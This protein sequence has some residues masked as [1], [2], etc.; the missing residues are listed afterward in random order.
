[1]AITNAQQYQQLVN[2]PAGNK[3]PGYR[4]D[5]AYGK[6][7]G[8][9]Q[10]RS[11]G[12]A[13]GQ[14]GPGRKNES[15]GDGPAPRADKS[16][17]YVQYDPKIASDRAT[18]VA[19]E[20]P[21][22]F[23]NRIPT[24][25]GIARK[26]INRLMKN[27][28]EKNRIDYLK[29]NFPE[30]FDS[31]EDLEK[32]GKEDLVNLPAYLQGL[33]DDD[34]LYTDQGLKM[35]QNLGKAE[36]VESFE[37]FMYNVKGS[38]GLKLAGN[39]GQLGTR[40]AVRDADGNIIGYKFDEKR[41]GGRDDFILPVSQPVA[42]IP[43]PTGYVNPLSLLTPRIAGTRFLG[44]EFKDEEDTEFAADGGRIGA[45]DGG[46][47]NVEDL[48]REA[49]IFG[50]IAKGLKK[51]VRGVKK[52]VKSPIGKAALIGAGFGF[53]GMGP[54]KGLAGSKFGLGLK[55]FMAFGNPDKAFDIT[56]KGFKLGQFIADNPYKTIGGISLLA[57][58]LAGKQED[59][60]DELAKY[61]ASQKLDPATTA[62]QMGSEFDFYKYNLAEGGMPSKEPVAKKTMPLLDMDGQEMD[63][64]AEGGFVPIGR[65]ERADDVPARLSKNE[66]V[67]TADAVRNA[68]E[69]DIDKGAE[70]MYNMMKNLE[71]GGEVSEES[72]GLNG[73][74]EMFQTSKR[75]EEVL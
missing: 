74:R 50:G 69:G 65:M 8:S 51:A 66:F 55:N 37:D 39:V 61:L 68:G 5:A 52:L 36:G 10:A 28:L 23:F 57:P 45:M 46:I 16:P 72:Q 22:G 62:R 60:N 64:R 67:F 53:A 13:R 25:I 14:T 41:G 40:S 11:I 48:D 43:E 4:G 1:M 47:M 75:L 49:F 9:A 70:V 15:M 20:E 63:L 21:K 12:Q 19:L 54:F 24:T 71:S 17:N 27:Q 2:K 26:G 18:K 34:K 56:G 58:L 7:S 32:L 6:D 33:V 31:E 35:I 73:A 59:D 42:S 30:Y 44:T 38:P 29:R 3:R